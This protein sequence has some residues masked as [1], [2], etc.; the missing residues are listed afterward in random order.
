MKL[1]I[2]NVKTTNKE[3]ANDM[4]VKNMEFHGINLNN[5]SVTLLSDDG[6]L[7]TSS[8]KKITIETQNSTYELERV[9]EVK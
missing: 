3:I 1:K 7:R 6:F 9:E 5:T 4:R 8:I 2:T